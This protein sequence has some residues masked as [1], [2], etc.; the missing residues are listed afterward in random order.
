M[1]LIIKAI[2]MLPETLDKIYNKYLKI[3]RK[4]HKQ[5]NC[6]LY[7]GCVCVCSSE[8]HWKGD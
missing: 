4:T 2:R 5:A 8:E 6:V 1:Q 7:A 3:L